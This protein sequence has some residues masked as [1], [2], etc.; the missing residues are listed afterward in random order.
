MRSI[1]YL[2]PALVLTLLALAAGMPRA[3]AQDA[4]RYVTPGRNPRRH[5]DFQHGTLTYQ[6]ANG[7]PL[8]QAVSNTVTTVVSQVAAVDITPNT[9]TEPA[10][11]LQTVFHALDV[12]NLG[13]APDTFT[14]TV[15]G[16]DPGWSVVLYRDLN[17]N[18]DLDANEQAAGPI[19]ATTQLQP[20][21]RFDLI[22]A[23]TTPNAATAPNGTS[24]AFT[25]TATSQFNT[26]VSDTSTLT[27]TITAAVIDLAK[28]SNPTAVNPGGTVTFTLTYRNTGTAPGT[29]AVVAD[30]IPAGMTFVPGSIR[31]NGTTIT[32]AGDGDA[33]DFGGT[34]PNRVTVNIG[35]VNPGDT[36]TITFQATVNQ[37]VASGTGL[38]NIATL[39]YQSGGQTITETSNPSTVTVSQV[40]GID[41]NPVGPI[42]GTTDPAVRRTSRS[43][44]PT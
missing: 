18:N 38:Q 20:G 29:A 13:N 21:E 14:L 41:L 22:A 25:V 16:V 44:S 31:L 12:F 23:V 15:A 34:A 43:P 7:N 27:T 32:D 39:T 28:T 24:D 30:P 1:R 6:D 8:P 3:W 35:T 2:L 5:R 19:T 17:N 42:T 9:A 11:N 36:G 10:G 26:G 37:N 4:G 33:G 40:A